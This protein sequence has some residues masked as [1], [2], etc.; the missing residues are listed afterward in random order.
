MH[1]ALL[2]LWMN[3]P[4]GVPQGS[5]LG[6]LL[7]MLAI[8]DIPNCIRYSR[9][10]LFVDDLKILKKI[11]TF[12]DCRQLQNY[13]R[14]VL[15]WSKEAG[16]SFNYKKCGVISFTRETVHIEFLYTLEQQ[17]TLESAPQET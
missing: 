7:F 16:L 8:N 2:V 11:S 4:P 12:E 10:L 5:N 3:T 17:M 14:S 13:L 15:A 6:P 9:C 1:E